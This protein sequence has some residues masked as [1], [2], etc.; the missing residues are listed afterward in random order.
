MCL[1]HDPRYML[2]IPIPKARYVLVSR[3][4]KGKYDLNL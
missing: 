4:K 1:I 3:D 2:K